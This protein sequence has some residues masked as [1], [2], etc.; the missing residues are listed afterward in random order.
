MLGHCLPGGVPVQLAHL[1]VR[2]RVEQ[3]HGRQQHRQ[4]FPRADCETAG[5]LSAREMSSSVRYDRG[6]GM[7]Q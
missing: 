3:Q 6:R 1:L 7:A 2:A 5:I 4:H